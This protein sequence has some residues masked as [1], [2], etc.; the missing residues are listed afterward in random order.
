[1]DVDE[2]EADLLEH[3]ERHMAA[4]HEHHVA[5]D[6]RHLTRHDERVLARIDGLRL[7]EVPQLLLR[8]EREHRFHAQPVTARADGVRRDALPEDRAERIDED[9]LARARLTREDI[10]PRVEL[11]L[12][13]LEQR[14]IPYGQ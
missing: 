6:P 4:V 7:Q 12:D 1:M 5:P 9:G 8:L 2:H 14:E 13:M 3:A 11:D 10:Q